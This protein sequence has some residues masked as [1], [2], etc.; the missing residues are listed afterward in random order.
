MLDEME[1]VSSAIVSMAASGLAQALNV[2]DRLE[3]GLFCSRSI[4][5]WPTS[6]SA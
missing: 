4:I 2:V 1:K 3:L 6:Y 5:A